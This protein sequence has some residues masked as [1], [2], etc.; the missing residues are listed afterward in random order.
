VDVLAGG[1]VGGEAL[2][3]RG[4]GCRRLEV[5]G[6]RAE[7]ALGVLLLHWVGG[8]WLSS[9]ARSILE[10]ACVGREASKAREVDA[11][12]TQAKGNWI[13]RATRES[14]QSRAGMRPMMMM[15][16]WGEEGGTRRGFQTDASGDMFFFSLS[17][18]SVQ[19]KMIK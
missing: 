11:N 6:D 7:P 12:A 8:I 17:L 19:E 18:S 14:A 5:G 4:G 1:G 15:R 9:L 3:A 10:F 13:S 16:A 2:A